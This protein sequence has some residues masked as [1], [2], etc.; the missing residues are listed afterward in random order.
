MISGGEGQASS[1]AAGATY[2]TL[3]RANTRTVRE[4]PEAHVFNGDLPGLK[5]EEVE[6]LADQRGEGARRRRRT[7]LGTRWRG[8]PG[9]SSAASGCRK[10]RR[11]RR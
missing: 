7:T 4:T 5:K 10:M 3:S 11:R 8:A 9:S 2:L 6:A 1:P